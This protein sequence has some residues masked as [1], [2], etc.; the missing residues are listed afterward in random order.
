MTL[1]DLIRRTMPPV[2]WQEGDNI[3][4]HDSAFSQRMLKEHLSQHHDLASRRSDKVHKHVQ[5]IHRELLASRP[6]RI[7]DLACGPGLYANRLA[8]LGHEC[9]AIDYS[10]ASIAYAT[11]HAERDGLSCTYLQQDIREADYGQ[12]FSLAMLIY[13]ELNVFCPTDVRRIL[14]K[15]RAALSDG[16]LL[17]LEPHTFSAVETIGKQGSSWY[18]AES[19]LFSDKT[20]LCL[21]EHS[22]DEPNQ[23]AT[24]RY[25]IIDAATADVTRHALSYQAYTDEQYRSLLVESGFRD[26][27]FYPSLSAQAGE[28]QEG[29]IAMVARKQNGKP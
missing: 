23:I 6:S 27:C 19:A 22:W 4:W 14:T 12:S 11:K 18:S 13:G 8:A 21:E 16:G 10:P 25:F 5:W 9:V 24:V 3:P 1:L 17:L 7:L 20:H 28:S 2:P 26:I 15:A 29:L